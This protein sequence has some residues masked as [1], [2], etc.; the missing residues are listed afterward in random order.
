MPPSCALLGG[1][2]IGARVVL[3]CQSPAVIRQSQR[4]PHAPAIKSTRLLRARLSAT[5]PFHF[6]HAEGVVMQMRNVCEYM[7]V[8]DLCLVSF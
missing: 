8:L 1:F 7:L 5:R 4:T 2:T 6:V 3:L